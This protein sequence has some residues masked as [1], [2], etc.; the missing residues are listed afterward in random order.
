MLIS[1]IIYENELAKMY[2]FLHFWMHGIR[3]SANL[4]LTKSYR[5]RN[6]S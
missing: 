3:E 5:W 4:F 1:E 6:K 2:T